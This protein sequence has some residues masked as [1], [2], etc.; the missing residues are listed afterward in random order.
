MRKKKTG[1]GVGGGGG[2]GKQNVAKYCKIRHNLDLESMQQKKVNMQL[3]EEGYI[4]QWL[5][6]P[7]T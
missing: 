1:G 5:I 3:H 4:Q 6:Q 7:V 2:G